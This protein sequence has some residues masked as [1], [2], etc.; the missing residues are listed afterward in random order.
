MNITLDDCY[1]AFHR[2]SDNK[3]TICGD[4][5][6]GDTLNIGYKDHHKD[7]PL[8]YIRE[9]L[10]DDLHKKRGSVLNL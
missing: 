6:P 1:W 9:S 5:Q 3:V 7:T 10:T 2:G 4:L 8:Q